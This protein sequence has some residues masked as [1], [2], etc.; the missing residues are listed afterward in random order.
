MSKTMQ[1]NDLEKIW[2]IVGN[3]AYITNKLVSIIWII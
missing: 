2:F 1:W 3:D